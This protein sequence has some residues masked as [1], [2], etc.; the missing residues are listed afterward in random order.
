M[1]P[2]KIL[3]GI[4]KVTKSKPMTADSNAKHAKQDF[5][6]NVHLKAV[7]LLIKISVN[8][9]TYIRKLY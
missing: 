6:I 3:E 4:G 9:I 1:N 7:F 5:G 2:V 8:T